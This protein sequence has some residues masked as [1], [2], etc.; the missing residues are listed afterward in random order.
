M[1][2]FQLMG[3]FCLVCHVR[4]PFCFVHVVENHQFDEVYLYKEQNAFQMIKAGC[5]NEEMAC[6]VKETMFFSE[7]PPSFDQQNYAIPPM[8]PLLM[9]D[10]DVFDLGNRKLQVIHT[11]GH[12]QDSIMLWDQ[13]NGLLFNGDSLYNGPICLHFH[14]PTYG[15]SNLQEYILSMKRIGN[16]YVPR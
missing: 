16:R 1:G 7:P 4:Q 12:T 13:A 10:G 14:S 11:P 15:F 8:E 3:V 5:S 6:N 9:E 2:W